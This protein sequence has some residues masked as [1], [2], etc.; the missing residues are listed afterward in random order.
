MR[1][2]AILCLM[3]LAACSD[4]LEQDTTAGQVVAVVEQAPEALVRLISAENF[5]VKST[6]P[7]TGVPSG[8][9]AGREKEFNLQ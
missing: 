8:Q 4:A 1:R 9:A 2:L 6:I 3:S 7:V 5:S